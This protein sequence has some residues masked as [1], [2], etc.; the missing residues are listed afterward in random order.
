[1][2]YKNNTVDDTLVEDYMTVITLTM[3][4][5][6][7]VLDIAKR[8]VAENISS[9][10]ITDDKKEIIGILTER[11]IVKIIANEVPPGGI[12]AGSL[13]SS[14]PV[15]VKNNAPIEEAAKIMAGKKVRHLLVED[16][17]AN[18]IMGIITVTDLARY[19]RQK[20]RTGEELPASEVWEIFF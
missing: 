11:D 9:I 17:S 15:T 5:K 13:M 10:A 3:N 12:T 18:N 20:S 6:N 7:S 14:P 19:L 4:F 1:M 8:M 16:F 2:G